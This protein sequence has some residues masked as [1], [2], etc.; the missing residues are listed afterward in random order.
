MKKIVF[1]LLATF[2]F[3][4]VTITLNAQTAVNTAHLVAKEA[5]KKDSLPDAISYLK[6]QIPTLTV[7]A[8]KRSGYVFLGSV[9]EQMGLYADAG[10]SYATAAGIAAT[11]AAGMPKKSNEQLVLDAVR[12]ALSSGDTTTAD[13]YLNSAVRNSKSDVILAYVKLY[14]QWSS[15]CKAQTEKDLAEP[16]AMLKTYTGLASMKSVAPAVL[17]TLWHV[18]GEQTY[19]DTLKKSYPAS[20]ETAVVKGV[21]QQLPAPFWYFVP[22]IGSVIPEVEQEP[23]TYQ[24]S[25]D[26]KP[27]ATTAKQTPTESTVSPK[28]EAKKVKSAENEKQEKPLYQ[29]LGLFKDSNNANGLVEQLKKK[30]F[31][32]RVTSEKRPS[33]TTYYLVVVDENKDG[34]M[35]NEL[36]NAG[37][38]CYGV[39]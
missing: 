1:F 24:Q 8:E 4:L 35:G 21:I 16:I 14:E 38:E 32:A 15:L 25:A 34:T 36:R 18:S 22:R 27:S 2:F 39:Y 29:Q 20:P 9:Q 7:A 33:G 23:V 12:C 6:K 17:L 3:S 19:A 37:F 26:E 5:A 13:N 31:S 11:D 30:G 28:T 10:K